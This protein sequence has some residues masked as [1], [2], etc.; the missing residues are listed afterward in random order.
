MAPYAP[1]ILKRRYGGQYSTS[2]KR[3]KV[4]MVRKSYVNY[5][6]YNTVATA[7]APSRVELKYD[8][9]VVNGTIDSTPNVVLLTTI[10]NGS[11]SSERIGK[12]VQY[13]S[14]EIAWSLRMAAVHNSNKAS[15]KLIYDRSPNGIL[16]AYTDI[17]KSSDTN[18]LLNPD[19]RARF[20]ELFEANW[21]TTNDVVSGN[22]NSIGQVHGHKLISMKGKKATFIG[23]ADTIASIETGAI[24]V[25]TNSYD[26]N[27]VDLEFTNKINFSDS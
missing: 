2:T 4:G 10:A 1:K 19:T 21:V 17:L 7:P 12:A 25:V 16:P 22:T 5:P 23:T 14:I 24:Y 9:G 15:F 26:D 6:V 8:Y 11:G 27:V 20:V 3:R 13:H 18:S